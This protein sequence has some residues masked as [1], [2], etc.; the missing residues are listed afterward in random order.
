MAARIIHS[1]EEAKEFYL[2]DYSLCPSRHRDE[3]PSETMDSYHQFAT[4]A[5]EEQ[6]EQ[7]EYESLMAQITPDNPQNLAIFSRAMKRHTRTMPLS[8]IADKMEILA[9]GVLTEDAA[10]F[11]L[12]RALSLAGF[13]QIARNAPQELAALDRLM[14]LAQYLLTY[15]SA[16]DAE[17]YQDAMTRNRLKIYGPENAQ[18]AEQLYRECLCRIRP[19]QTESAE[20][21]FAAFV[22][23]ATELQWRQKLFDE[24]TAPDFCLDQH[25]IVD[26]LDLLKPYYGIYSRENAERLY[27]KL[28][29]FRN[30]LQPKNYLSKAHGITMHIA[31]ILYQEKEP[32]LLERF[33]D[34]TEE[35]LREA[36]DDRYFYR[37]TQRDVQK[38]RALLREMLVCQ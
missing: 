12:D 33:L 30:C 28:A 16:K 5:L 26:E 37:F 7:E 24:R 34:L 10:V 14:V 21:K 17:K 27:R 31:E 36:E 15:C 8:P 13:S 4:R 29:D 35:I 25:A 3:Y 22:G 18:E 9:K 19:L 2:Q 11:L 32:D 38:Y 6:W 23:E 20:R 1:P